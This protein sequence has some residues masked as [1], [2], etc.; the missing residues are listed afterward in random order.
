MLFFFW[1]VAGIVLAASV[2]GLIFRARLREEQV[3]EELV[4][5]NAPASAV[6]PERQ[7]EPDEHTDPGGKE[8]NTS[9]PTPTSHS[10]RDFDQRRTSRIER[11]VPLLI[12]G[13]NPRGE[14]FQER[15]S[16]VA[17]NLHGCRYSSR[18]E[19]APKSW[20]T[21]QITGTD[22]ANSHGV[23]A[24]VCSVLSPRTPRELC[25]VGVELEIPGN[26]WGIP[27]PPEDWQR[28][29]GIS[30]SGARAAAAVAPALDP[31]A[32]PNSF[33]EGQ[34]APAERR[35][36]VTVFPGSPAPAAATEAEVSPATDP[37]PT[38]V[39]RVVVTVE[40]LLQT[41]QGKLQIAADKAVQTSL[42]TQF[43][44]ALK[45]ALGKIEDSCEATL[46]QT[47]ES[48][49]VRLAE[50]QNLWE[51]ELVIYRNRA[52][53]I[54]RRIETL[55]TNSHQA[56]SET[57]KFVARFANET[58]P[59]LRARINDSF[60]RAGNE[61]EAKVAQVSQQH[62]AEISQST[63]LAAR[64][65]RSQLEESIAEVRSLLS[66]TGGGT[67]QERIESLL[68]SFKE[69]TLNHLEERLGDLHRG[70][71]M[72]HDLTR[73]R[74]DEIARELEGLA[75]VR[76]LLAN[77]NAGVP[78]DRL[79]SLLN[80]SREQ[81]LS[82]LEWR[83]GEVSGHY[84]QL[85]GQAGNR[86]DELAQKV[87]KLSAETSEHLTET[88]SLAE[89]ASREL[90]PQDLSA[91]EQ[92][93]S[94]AT[95]EFESAAARV[96]DRQLVRL[97]EQKQA[98]SQ[99]IFLEL[100]AR[101]SEARALLQKA[102]N[103]ALEEFQRRVELQVDLMLAEAKESVASSLASLDAESRSA[104]EARRHALEADVARAAEQSTMEFRSGI[105]AFLYSCLVAAVGAVDQ[106]AQTTLAGLSGNPSSLPG[107]L[108]TSG[109]SSPSSDN[110][111]SQPKTSSRSE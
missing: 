30:N 53:E 84:E 85:L 109:S 54:A 89:R 68:H 51:K 15:T 2:L 91:I 74:V 22:G 75:D 50:A 105:K 106:H 46:L 82:Q 72:E 17:M 37:A 57:Q 8:M 25:Q 40:Q 9:T 99:E 33:L 21:L 76:A 86:A 28:L 52:E 98:V 3:W 61:F 55:T 66:A 45:I 83:L 70:F 7:R 41:L 58:A 100:E 43:D 26:V 101:A 102:A 24:R 49:S 20:V 29:L 97:M 111:P 62:L 80:S 94:H 104:V 5:P 1:I 78:Q 42:S 32:P 110:P 18:H 64:E 4:D 60:G 14:T 63:Q 77:V 48:S 93:V 59:Q 107:A 88:R 65:A 103:G 31:A 73:H 11:L 67:S 27:A 34:A 108:D 71:G 12:V 92:S 38:E 56:L 79:D 35:A 87:E 90:R 13:T 16:A 81:I 95:K 39:K 10:P 19:Y 47:E 36:E 44:E 23:R 6:Q 96:S 69:E